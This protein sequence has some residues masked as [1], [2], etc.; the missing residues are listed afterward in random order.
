MSRPTGLRTVPQLIDA[1]LADEADRDALTE[2]ARR[3]PVGVSPAMAAVLTPGDPVARQLL[4]TPAELDVAPDEHPDPIGDARHSP[5]P[6]LVHRYPD[7]VL[8]TPTLLCAVYCRFCFRRDVVGDG[9][10]TDAELAAALDYIRAHPQIWEVILTGGDPL[11]LAPRRLGEI[12]AALDAIPHVRVLRVHTRVPLVA[13]ERVNDDLLE[14]LRVPTPVYVALH[15]NHARE[16]TPAGRAACARLVD[17]GLPMLSQTVLLR[18][19]NDSVEALEALMRTF[20]ENRIRP[21]Y[22][23]LLDRA[24][25]TRHFR[26]PLDEGQRLV[27]TLRGRVS[28]LAQP[29]FVLDIPGGHGKVPIG[30]GYLHEGGEVEDPWGRRHRLGEGR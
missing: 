25:G 23:H 14:A 26:V 10:L 11:V 29:V 18:G 6:G 28:G 20:V 22:L 30:P 21:Y 2:V 4:P 16:F 15:S 3:L 7:R 8:L 1:G 5:L 9:V 27:R 24:E 13:P 19:V 12:I 17:H